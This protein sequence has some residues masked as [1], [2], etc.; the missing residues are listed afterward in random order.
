MNTRIFL[1]FLNYII[2]FKSKNHKIIICVHR[3]KKVEFSVKD[4]AL[5]KWVSIKLILRFFTLYDKAQIFPVIRM[6][7]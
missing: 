2:L 3:E 5:Q 4:N 7:Q 1:L 6:F